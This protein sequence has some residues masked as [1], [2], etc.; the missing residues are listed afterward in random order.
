MNKL[1]LTRA[2]ERASESER[3]N[4]VRRFLCRSSA[5]FR[6]V[7]VTQNPRDVLK[8][9]TPVLSGEEGSGEYG[10]VVYIQT[11]KVLNLWA[12]GRSGGRT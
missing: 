3:K 6:S 4:S 11:K 10:S 1:V 7:A 8:Y 5:Y 12:G 2:S 9:D